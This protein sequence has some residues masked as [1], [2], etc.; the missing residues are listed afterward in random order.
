[1]RTKDSNVTK[2]GVLTKNKNKVVST[3]DVERWNVLLEA[4]SGG[5]GTRVG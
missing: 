3:G 1:M 4:R 2:C 5:H